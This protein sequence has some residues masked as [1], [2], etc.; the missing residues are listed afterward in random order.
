N[1]MHQIYEAMLPADRE[2]SPHGLEIGLLKYPDSAADLDAIFR[3]FA[4]AGGRWTQ[5]GQVLDGNKEEVAELFDQLKGV[6]DL[7]AVRDLFAWLLLI[8]G[9]G[10]Q[11]RRLSRKLDTLKL[12]NGYRLIGRA[13]V[14]Y[15]RV[16]TALA[17]DRDV[18]RTEIHCYGVWRELPL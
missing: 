8:P 9:I 13:H 14:D 12:T 17:S 18:L 6:R 1:L 16:V 4:D 11:L 3:L 10:S 5:F 7:K 2:P 15:S